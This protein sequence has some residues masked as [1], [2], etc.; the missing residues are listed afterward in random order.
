[1]AELY[2]SLVD[3]FEK[4]T[5]Q[6]PHRPL[7]GTKV[8]GAWRW[9]TYDELRKDVDRFR[10]ALARLGVGPGDRVALISRNSVE[11]AIAAYAT[12]GR[13]AALVPMYEAQSAEE[14]EYILSDSGAKLAIG[15]TRAIYDQLQLIK[16]RLPALAH[17]MG[18]N[19]PDTD[20]WSFRSHI[21]RGG[22]TPVPPE[23]PTGSDLAGVLYTSG[24]TGKPKGV[25]LTHDNFCSNVNAVGDLFPYSSDERSLAFLPWAHAF[26]QTCELHTGIALGISM[27]LNDTVERLVENL[28]EVRPTILFAVPRVFN[29]LYDVVHAQIREQPRPIRSL[30]RTA[31]RVARKRSRGESLNLA[32]RALL[33]TADRLIF[34]KIRA[35]FGGRLKWVISGSA[36]LGTEVAEFIDALG[37]QV[38]EGYGLT[39]TSPIVTV[40]TIEHRK[41]GS[42]GRPI[43]GVRVDIDKLVTGDPKIGEIVVHGPNVMLGYHNLPEETSQ[44]MTPDGGFR[45]GDLGYVDRD[46]FLYITGR[47]KEQYKLSNG[48][49]VAPSPIE[50]QLKLSPYIANAMVHGA[51]M[52][53]NVAV[54]VVDRTALE[55]WAKDRHLT[56]HDPAQDDHVLALLQGEME[57]QSE[58]LKPFE[59]PQRFVVATEDFT[60]ENG[61]LTPTLKLRRKR[62]LE[63]YESELQRLY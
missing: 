6:Y 24:T 52:P 13:K 59:R 5:A 25:R 11:W 18:V 48:K 36:A 14:W 41:I 43:E 2:S 9:I 22:A 17:V 10:A 42:V 35:R 44:T 63:R 32:D 7:F 23:V 46:G 19:L 20:E 3:L 29:R 53:Y 45:T 16:G 47:I 56:V 21:I 1:M 61:L 34:A 8:G 31:V 60:T 54:L 57:R 30:F 26:G 33:A 40:N 51:N 62:V 28:P 4:S 27:A 38:Y 49:Y 37:I 39:E 55:R 58:P 50:E 12:F 15:S